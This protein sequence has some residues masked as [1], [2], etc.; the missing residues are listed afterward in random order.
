MNAPEPTVIH[1]RRKKADMASVIGAAILGGGLGAL[2]AQYV[3]LSS[4]AVALVVVGIV[5]HA[6]GMLERHRL[7]TVASQVWWAEALYWACWLAIL[8]I[9]AGVVLIRV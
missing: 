5:M 2:A 3:N 6:W 7:D 8:V 1:S 9:I 4:S